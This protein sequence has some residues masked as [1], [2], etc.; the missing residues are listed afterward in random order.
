LEREDLPGV[1]C[2]LV[3]PPAA[4]INKSSLEKPVMVLATVEFP[5]AIL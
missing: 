5:A 4:G 1:P 2:A 3:S